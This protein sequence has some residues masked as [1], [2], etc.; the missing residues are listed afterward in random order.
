MRKNRGKKMSYKAIH[1]KNTSEL[2]MKVLFSAAKLFVE[3]GYG[4]ATTRGI[5]KAA[6]VNVTAMNRYFKTKDGILADLVKYVLEGQFKATE[7]KLAGITDDKILFY[8]AE[9]TLQLYMAESNEH[10]RDLYCS[11]Y[12]LP[13]TSSIIQQMITG[14]L[15][16]I[17]KE[18]LPDLE[19][20][21]FYKLE[22]A[23]GGIMRGFLTIPCDMCFTMDQKVESF[24]KS[25]LKIY[26]V[27]KEKIAEA[28]AFVSKID[29]KI[30]AQE[31]I[32]GMLKYL[33]ENA[34]K[35]TEGE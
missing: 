18:H 22:I 8:A 26:D 11:A 23:S 24:L 17:F 30:F 4:S 6:G 33:E 12:S 5:A 31:T 35:V 19:T 14:K 27:P 28:I 29:F 20:K 34:P 9:T 21:D 13:Q 32:N 16:D 2:R 15:E 3:K 10:I 1:K 25:T 7:E